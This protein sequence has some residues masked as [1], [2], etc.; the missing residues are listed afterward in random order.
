MKKLILTIVIL[1]T[2]CNSSIDRMKEFA[3]QT[4]RSEWDLFIEALIHVESRGDT[5]AVGA[6]N[7]VGVLQITPIYVQDVNRILGEE[8]Y[9]L[10]CR[11]S[12]K[13]SLEMFN[14]YQSH[15][16]PNKSIDKAI[17]LHNP[18]AGERYKAKVKNKL[19]E[20]L[21]QQKEANS[22]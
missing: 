4:V 10:S 19:K 1:L 9:T 18:R 20:L 22:I 16:N 5:E 8:R 14:V 7:D 3:G 17:K 21:C 12:V 15:Y 2:G 13:K 6:K 11:V